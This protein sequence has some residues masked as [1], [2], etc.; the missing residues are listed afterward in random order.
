MDPHRAQK[1][2][3]CLEKYGLIQM[4]Q[5]RGAGLE[6]YTPA[7]TTSNADAELARGNLIVKDVPESHDDD[8]DDDSNDAEDDNCE[9]PVD[10][11]SWHVPEGFTLAPQPECVNSSCIG[12]FVF[13]KWE[14]FGW[15]LGKISLLT[16]SGVTPR[17][18]S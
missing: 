13:M 10:P 11:V 2:V 16:S 18:F 17:A 14:G 9:T 5:V 3:Y 12:K 8:T 15:Q 4:Q 1:A 7:E 6:Y